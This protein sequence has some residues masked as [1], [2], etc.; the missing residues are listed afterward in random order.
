MHASRFAAEELEDGEGDDI[1]EQQGRGR[2]Q[3]WRAQ[4]GRGS[5][6]QDDP[7]L[8]EED[9]AE[10]ADADDDFDIDEANREMEEKFLQ[11]CRIDPCDMQLM[12]LV[13]KEEDSDDNMMQDCQRILAYFQNKNVFHDRQLAMEKI[14]QV[15]SGPR[16][17]S[18][19]AELASF[20]GVGGKKT[21]KPEMEDPPEEE[22]EA[23]QKKPSA[24]RLSK[25][26]ENVL[27]A[28]A[29]ARD[30][31][32]PES[33]LKTA[34]R[35]SLKR[36]STRD[37]FGSNHG[38]RSS[39]RNKDE[40]IEKPKTRKLTAFRQVAEATMRSKSPMAGSRAGSKPGG[41]GKGGWN[42]LKTRTVQRQGY[43]PRGL[44]NMI[45]KSRRSVED[46]DADN[47]AAAKE[48][49]EEAFR[50]A[51]QRRKSFAVDALPGMAE[52]DIKRASMQ[53][54][55]SIA[56]DSFANAAVAMMEKEVRR[57]SVMD[58]NKL[59]AK[60]GQAVISG[61]RASGLRVEEESDE[62]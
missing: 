28:A 51:Q 20:Y 62:D 53:R 58:Y 1:E 16:A 6:W 3:F 22:P 5:V 18:S 60:Q 4:S 59:L 2:G 19:F 35:N 21:T 55:K 36:S 41:A 56:V 9:V 30:P 34:L 61:S 13:T 17:N 32:A 39:L 48:A 23:K 29:A 12:S 25:E 8:D 27:K 40:E 49:D 52:E 46:Q 37:D 38:K 31:D 50:N 15:L 14:D 11:C 54:K 44:R 47:E 10:L 57:M 45:T 33:K 42:T 43:V 24:A 26:D 7:G